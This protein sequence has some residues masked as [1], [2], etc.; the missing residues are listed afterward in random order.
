MFRYIIFQSLPSL[1]TSDVGTPCCLNSLKHLMPMQR[2]YFSQIVGTKNVR[3]RNRRLLFH[4][5]YE[6][7]ANNM[8]SVRASRPRLGKTAA[9]FNFL[10]LWRLTARCIFMVELL[11]CAHH[12][13]TGR[14][15][16]HTRNSIQPAFFQAHIRLV[17]QPFPVTKGDGS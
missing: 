7:S 15:H 16:H 11:C 8:N 4:S 10:S 3:I 5:R 14:L 9:I 12:A 2:K 6:A 1:L 17:E 13:S